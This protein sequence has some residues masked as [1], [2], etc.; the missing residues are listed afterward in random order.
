MAQA[1]ANSPDSFVVRCFFS[2]HGDT[3]EALC[4]DYDVAVQGHS[5][6][7]VYDRIITAVSEYLKY[8][9]T[10]PE[11][12]RARFRNRGV[13]LGVRLWCTVRVLWTVIRGG[14]DHREGGSGIFNVP[15]HA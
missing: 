3:W 15:S 4:V 8:I 1:M 2:Q 11:G 6:A 10:L 14:S 13:P 9:E 5:Y 12:E 7:E